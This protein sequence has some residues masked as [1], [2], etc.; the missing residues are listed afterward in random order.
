MDNTGKIT[1]TAQFDKTFPFVNGMAV[2]EKDGL[3]NYIDKTGKIILTGDFKE[4]VPFYHSK[5]AVVKFKGDTKHSII[6]N[7]GKVLSKNMWADDDVKFYDELTVKEVFNSGLLRSYTGTGINAIYGYKDLTGNWVVKP[8]YKEVSHFTAGLAK[9]TGAN[10]FKL[11]SGKTLDLSGIIN[12]KGELVF[13]LEYKILSEP[14]YNTPGGEITISGE[15]KD[16]GFMIMNTKG[17][18]LLG[19]FLK[20]GD[21]Q[22]PIYGLTPF[23]NN[24]AIIEYNPSRKVKDRHYS[25]L[26]SSVCD[27]IE[28]KGMVVLKEFEYIINYPVNEYGIF[29][30]TN[31][32][33][34]NQLMFTF[35]E[36]KEDTT[37]KMKNGLARLN[38]DIIEI[39]VNSVI[40]AQPAKRPGITTTYNGWGDYMCVDPYSVSNACKYFEL[41][42]AIVNKKILWK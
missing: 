42:R 26:R 25:S 36:E 39:T 14:W 21:K 2:A 12:T 6:N 24:Y 34:A 9:V 28:K 17:E 1:I 8:Q 5:Y 35:S 37:I 20:Y 38:G 7:E 3:S 13:P 40:Q 22:G 29:G 18:V 30:F 31:C 19:P 10:L 41:T 11:K 27:I 23:K 15:H 32:L 16:K 4:T 33:A